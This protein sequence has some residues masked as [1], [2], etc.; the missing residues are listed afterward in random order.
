MDQSIRIVTLGH[1]SWGGSG[2][3][4]A[5]LCDALG[6]RRHAVA[7]VSLGPMPWLLDPSVR[8]PVVDPSRFPSSNLHTSWSASERGAFT[9]LVEAQVEE[10]DADILHAHY[11][12]PFAQIVADIAS[13]IR[14]PLTT[15]MTLH[16]TDIQNLSD[17]DKHALQSID[18]LTT[19]SGSMV[20]R[21]AGLGLSCVLLPNLIDD[22]WRERERPLRAS[23]PTIVHVSNHRTV[24]DPELLIRMLRRL[25][26]EM[27]CDVKLVGEGPELL[28]LKAEFD[29]CDCSN[30][31]QFVGA[32][33]DPYPHIAGSDLLL[34][35]S[36]EESFSL[37]ALEAL[38]CGVP[39]AAPAIGGLTDLIEDGVE[40]LLFDR[41]NPE[42]AIARILD[43]LASQ[44]M[45]QR[46]SRAA[47]R[48][49]RVFSEGVVTP[50]FEAFYRQ[51]I[52]ARA[53]VLV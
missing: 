28:R 39:V 47:E 43:C 51:A 11:V 3:A 37:V 53:P 48:R 5:R 35:T 31:V 27:D 36:R 16:G 22:A 6:R 17:E 18:C 24:K 38:A 34:L 12:Q 25:L 33:A 30:R 20:K 42:A 1:A 26:G 52:A 13:R 44:E 8:N 9:H 2:R 50:R 14:R 15:V 32:V 40:G 21:A 19:V 45:L 10:M 4:A 46:L 41:D 7:L 23:R 49:A 29:A